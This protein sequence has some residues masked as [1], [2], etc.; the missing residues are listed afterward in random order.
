MDCIEGAA[1]KRA[2]LTYEEFTSLP[3][4][5][6]LGMTGNWGAQRMYRNERFGVQ[7]E[8]VTER[9]T[10]GDLYGGWKEPKVSFFLDG[11]P[12]E[13][14]NSAECYEAYMALVCKMEEA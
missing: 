9:E 6:T 1:M 4:Q 5:Y 12:R 10:P 11:D 7:K 13:F 8:V 14:S 2:E 3:M